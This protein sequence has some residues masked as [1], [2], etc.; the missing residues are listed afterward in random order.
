MGNLLECCKSDSSC[1]M[2]EGVPPWQLAQKSETPRQDASSQAG[3]DEWLRNQVHGGR[4]DFVTS[5]HC[6]GD[7]RDSRLVP[8]RHG[9]DSN[10]VRSNDP[11]DADR[12]Y[13]FCQKQEV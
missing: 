9:C 3:P 5:S 8:P 13:L 10:S 6:H 11:S 12:Y 1:R 7:H 4:L 2:S